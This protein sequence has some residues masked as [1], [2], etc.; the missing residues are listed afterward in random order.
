ML[1]LLLSRLCA[2]NVH[3]FSLGK[4]LRTSL[5]IRSLMR[6]RVSVVEWAWLGLEWPPDLYVASFPI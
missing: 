3:P 5:I 2:S 4:Y 6:V 1:E